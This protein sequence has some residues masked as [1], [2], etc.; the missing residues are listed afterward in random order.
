VFRNLTRG[1]GLRMLAATMGVAALVALGGGAVAQA[2]TV[3]ASGG[4]GQP[5]LLHVTSQAR[6][7]AKA[8][9]IKATSPYPSNCAYNDA[10]CTYDTGWTT[11]NNGG[12]EARVIATWWGMPK[13]IL[14]V[15][16]D[17]QSP[18]LFAGCRAYGNV[19]FGMNS[20]PP[21][22]GGSFYSYACAVL[23]PTCSDNQ[24]W[25]YQVNQAVPQAQFGNLNSIYANI[26]H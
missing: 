8:K 9:A 10:T 24:S 5:V 16:V 13:N 11:Y 3:Q 7:A 26:T 23:D 21:I 19:Y 22:S 20:G 4:H 2:S 18:Y 15:T 1:R 12:C 6:T 25:S 17:V 14:N